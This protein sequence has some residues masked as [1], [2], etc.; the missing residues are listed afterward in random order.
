DLVGFFVNTLVL[1]TD[2]AGD[3]TFREL[4]GRVRTADLDAF[5]HQETPFD[6]VLEAVNP[7]RTLSRHPLFQI[8]LALESGSGP[9]FGLRGVRTGPVETISNGSAKF[10]LEFF[11][12]SDDEKSL[13]ATVLFA[14]ELFDEVTVR[15]M[16]RILGDVLAQV[17]DEPGVRLSGLEVLSGAERELLTGPWA[18]TA[19]DIGDVSLVER[20]EEQVARHPGRTALVDGERRITYAEL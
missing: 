9:A 6:L 2:S 8:C 14:A 16:T 13:R 7:T 18:G 5:A 10:D 12:R 4:L 20:F 3:P 1:R 17:L 19:A 11:L 15:R